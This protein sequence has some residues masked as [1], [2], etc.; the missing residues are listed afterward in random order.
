IPEKKS[1]KLMGLL[2][3]KGVAHAAIIGKVVAKSK[4]CIVIKK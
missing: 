1:G 2:K 3:K 4:G